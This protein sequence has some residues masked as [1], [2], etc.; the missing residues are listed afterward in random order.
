MKTIKTTLLKQSTINLAVVALLSLLTACAS[1]A[2]PNA[3]AQNASPDPT[4]AREN[5]RNDLG[6]Q[7]YMGAFHGSGM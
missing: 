2:S 4:A 1:T 5:I 3:A 7:N 6:T